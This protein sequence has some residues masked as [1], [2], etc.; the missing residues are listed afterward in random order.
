MLNRDIRVDLHIHSKASEYKERVDSA[1]KNIVAE[2]DIDHLD[3]LFEKLNETQNSINVISITDHNRFDPALYEAINERIANGNS[4]TVEAILAGVEFDV[5]FQSDKPHAHVIA[6]FDVGDWST[7]PDVCK[8]NYKV[9]QDGIDKDKITDAND[10]YTLDR[11]ESILKNIGLNVILIAHQHQGLTSQN[12]KKRTLSSATDDAIDYVKF[13]YIDALEYTKSRVQGI[14]LS[15]L[16]NLDVKASTIVGS[17]CHTWETY[18]KHDHDDSRER[19]SYYSTI[20][21]LPTFKSLLMAL[22]SSDTCFQQPKC[23]MKASYIDHIEVNG[24]RVDLCPGINAI[25]GENGAGKSSLLTMLTDEHLP[26]YVKSFLTKRNTIQAD[27]LL[28]GDRVVSIKQGQ[29]EKSYS[30]DNGMFESSLYPEID[31]TQF[32]AR[33][34][35]WSKKVKERIESNIESATVLDKL[36]S[37]SFK[38]EPDLEKKHVLHSDR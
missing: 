38:L 29:L 28:N 13:G 26:Q 20:R 1:G 2:S 22:T 27:K 7:N 25:I 8:K 32:E 33:A 6:I 31:N 23:E 35:N 10:K 37:T 18:P 16:V 4:G 5:Q 21:A 30:S 3:V 24:V 11:F 19:D 17:D 15:D 36:K 14:I 9:I 34:K 12:V